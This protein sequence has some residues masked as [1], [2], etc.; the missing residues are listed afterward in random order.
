MSHSSAPERATGAV[1]TDWRPEDPAFWQQR[2]QRIASRNLWI[3]VPCLLL[4]FCVWMLF[5][6]VAVNLPKVGFNFTTDQLF[7]LTALPSVSGALLRVPYSFMVP[8]FGGRRWT[9]FSTGI[10]I[11]PCV[12]LGFAV[13][14]TSTPYSVFIIISSAV[15]LCWR[16]LRIQ[17]GKH[18]L[19]LSETEAGWRA[20]SEWWSGQHGR[21]RHA[22]GCSAGGITVDFRSIW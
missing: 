4:A 8:I 11:I 14:D 3:S 17:Y 5:S 18:Q 6:A 15:R 21:Q 10:L 1:I 2:G 7:M 13:Q 22:V 12:W 9:A 16:E 19:L 20:G